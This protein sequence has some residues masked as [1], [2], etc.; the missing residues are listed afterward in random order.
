MSSDHHQV[1]VGAGPT[2][3]VAASLLGRYGVECLVLD[4]WED[5][6][7][8]P[9]AVHLD[10][11]VHRILGDLGV[12]DEFTAI[13]RPARGLRLIDDAMRPLAEFERDPE[14]GPHGFPPANL[15]DQPE[16]ER[17]LRARMLRDLRVTFRSGVEVLDVINAKDR[18]QVVV[19]DIATGERSAVTAD[20]VLG[21]Q[22][23]YA[24]FSNLAKDSGGF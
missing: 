19:L 16:L 20:I 14:S 2:G 10:D 5:I 24:R 7:P 6:F 3:M 4:R 8:Q 1:V 13:S 18:A 21:F 12:A 11:E 15:F 22:G 9:R 17:I 23:H